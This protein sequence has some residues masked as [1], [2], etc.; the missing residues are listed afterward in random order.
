MSKVI[1]R[2]ILYWAVILIF[3]V[4]IAT[5]FFTGGDEQEVL[6]LVFFSGIL[7]VSVGT[8]FVVDNNPDELSFLKAIRKAREKSLFW[9]M[10]FLGIFVM[11]GGVIGVFYLDI[12]STVPKLIMLFLAIVITTLTLE[13]L[14]RD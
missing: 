1:V 12:I 2:E 5:F 14:N 8:K 7:L 4:Y 3:S 6:Y 9:W 13:R 10:P 11:F